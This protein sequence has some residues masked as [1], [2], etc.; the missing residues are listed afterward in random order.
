MKLGRVTGLSVA[1]PLPFTFGIR[2]SFA[3]GLGTLGF[4][5]AL[6]A[7]S[8]RGAGLRLASNDRGTNAS[9]LVR[10][11]RPGAPEVGSAGESEGSV[12]L[13]MGHPAAKLGVRN[14]LEAHQ[15]RPARLTSRACAVGLCAKWPFPLW[16]RTRPFLRGPTPSQSRCPAPSRRRVAQVIPRGA[17]RDQKRHIGQFCHNSSFGGVPGR[18]RAG[19]DLPV[20]T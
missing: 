13:D 3:V 16:Q 14:Q 5:V 1:P 20:F 6:Q 10:R 19:G 9:V 2:L 11:L 7:G 15:G 8:G 4:A 12:G 18:P 17:P